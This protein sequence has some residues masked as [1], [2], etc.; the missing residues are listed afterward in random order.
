MS[1]LD[2]ADDL[3]TAVAI[4]GAAGILLTMTLS[5]GDA[6]TAQ[7]IAWATRDSDNRCSTLRPDYCVLVPSQGRTAH[8]RF[9][10]LVKP[11]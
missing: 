9:R 11:H 10:R 4:L 5:I 2:D 3:A 8:R 6:S 1:D 7:M